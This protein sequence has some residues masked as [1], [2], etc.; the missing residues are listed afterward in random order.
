MRLREVNSA[1]RRI[2]A[3]IGPVIDE[4]APKW[5][6]NHGKDREQHEQEHT[7]EQPAAEG[8]VG[9]SDEHD[10]ALRVPAEVCLVNDSLQGHEQQDRAPLLVDLVAES[11]VC[12]EVGI[13]FR[14]LAALVEPLVVLAH[15]GHVSVTFVQNVHAAHEKEQRVDAQHA[16][17]KPFDNVADACVGGHRGRGAHWGGLV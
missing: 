6:H 1:K 12:F 11:R 4:I 17:N 16:Q 8:P 9:E 15:L 13:K 10:R 14:I 2:H 7:Q 5:K 3:Q